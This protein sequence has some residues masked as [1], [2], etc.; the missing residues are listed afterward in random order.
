[1]ETSRFGIKS[2]VP[3]AMQGEVIRPPC[4]QGVDGFGE[5]DVTLPVAAVQGNLIASG[6][7]LPN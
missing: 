2:K 3:I 4:L 5:L 6:A 7:F 1:M